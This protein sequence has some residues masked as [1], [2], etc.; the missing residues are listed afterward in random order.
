MMCVGSS[1][2]AYLKDCMMGCSFLIFAVIVLL[3]FSVSSTTS[4]SSFAYAV[5]FSSVCC[6]LSCS[7]CVYLGWN[8]VYVVLVGLGRRLLTWK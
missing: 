2:F 1:L 7:C 5:C 3:Y 8:S 4:P 6:S